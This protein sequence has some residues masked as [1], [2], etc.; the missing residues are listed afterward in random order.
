[1]NARISYDAGNGPDGKPGRAKLE[2]AFSNWNQL[3]DIQVNF[4]GENIK[5]WAG[6]KLEASVMLERGFSPNASCP[7]GSYSFVKTG[8]EYVWARGQEVNLDA[9]TAGTWQ[10]VPFNIDVPSQANSPYDPVSIV[11]VGLQFYSNSVSGCSELPEPAVVYV[12][13]FTVEDAM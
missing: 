2:M 3:A 1:M 7:G 10:V 8:A 13:N 5:D 12:D 4:M 6:K 9:T 11:S